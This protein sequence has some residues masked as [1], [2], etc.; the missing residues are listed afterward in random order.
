MGKTNKVNIIAGLHKVFNYESIA[1]STT[2]VSLTASKYTDTD[3]DMAKRCVIKVE[4]GQLRYRMDG[5]NP[6]TTEGMLLNPMDI[7]V[8]LGTQNIENFRAIRKT[9]T[10]SK[11]FVQYEI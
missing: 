8:I 5:E 6:T 9:S 11:I 4:N 2:I 7:L 1:V 3:G 10:D